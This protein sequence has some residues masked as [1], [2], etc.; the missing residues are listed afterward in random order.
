MLWQ[1]RVDTSS[2]R[3]ATQQQSPVQKNPS[4]A[5]TENAL[6][7]LGKVCLDLLCCHKGDVRCGQMACIV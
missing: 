2:G 4:L 5:L 7:M 1:A 3:K 6:V